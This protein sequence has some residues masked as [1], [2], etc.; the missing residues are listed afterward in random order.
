M[1]LNTNYALKTLREAFVKYGVYLIST[2]SIE[3]ASN[4][5]LHQSTAA[6]SA[7]WYGPGPH[8]EWIKIAVGLFE[9]PIYLGHSSHPT[10]F[11]TALPSERL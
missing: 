10:L 5:L 8:L 1:F 6:A 11:F 2:I 3:R 9:G 7:W 4:K